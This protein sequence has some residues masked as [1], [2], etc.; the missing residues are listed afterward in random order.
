MGN[1][2]VRLNKFNIYNLFI[3]FLLIGILLSNYLWL[4]IDGRPVEGHGL[5]GLVPAV[6]IYRELNG[7]ENSFKNYDHILGVYNET[8]FYPPLSFLAVTLFY[9]LFGLQGQMVVMVNSIYIAVALICIY[10]IGKDIFNKPTG[11]LAAFILSSFPGFIAFSRLYWIEFGLMAYVTLDLYLLLKTNFFENRK[12]SILLGIS[13]A[14]SFLHKIEFISFVIG[15]LLL[16]AYK[17]GVLKD[18]FQAKWSKK[19]AHLALTLGLAV[20]LTSFWWGRYGK[21]ILGRMLLTSHSLSDFS[22][23]FDNI[24]Y[25]QKIV[26]LESLTFYPYCIA[27][28]V[29]IIFLALLILSAIFLLIKVIISDEKRSYLLFLV[30][31]F[32]VPYI[33]FTFFVMKSSSHMLS[34]LPCI[35]ILIGAGLYFIKNK[36]FKIILTILI[37]AY[38]LN[39]H[40][41]S[42]YSPYPIKILNTFNN[43]TLRY[44]Y[45]PRYVNHDAFL[46]GLPRKER[47]EGTIQEI[48]EYIKTDYHGGGY[49]S[50]LAVSSLEV[51]RNSIFEYYS[52]IGDYKIK[53]FSGFHL[54]LLNLS[55]CEYIIIERLDQESAPEI[56]SREYPATDRERRD[57]KKIFKNGLKGFELIKI[58]KAPKENTSVFIYKKSLNSSI[59]LTQRLEKQTTNALGH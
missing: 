53:F 43:F 34:I 56:L 20:A 25:V 3:F 42:F 35:A 11:L 59:I 21:E 55:E 5:V 50:V 49:P 57:F 51:F 37:F 12:Y 26:S 17:S 16:V 48:L 33:V 44:L 28:L 15:P 46:F 1:L 2:L 27:G 8:L 54:P 58:F 6:Q 19:T 38:C 18:I 52:L 10:L 47:I 30:I 23:G 4:K 14:L 31:S 41:Y 36:T 24:A 9:L 32:I 40:L 13:L 29:G 45:N 22:K 39:L 7:L